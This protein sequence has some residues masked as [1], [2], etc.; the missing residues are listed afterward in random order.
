MEGTTIINEPMSTTESVRD[1]ILNMEDEEFVITV[2]VG[3]QE[4]GSDGR[5]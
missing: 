5:E 4:G 1:R 2:P 3:L